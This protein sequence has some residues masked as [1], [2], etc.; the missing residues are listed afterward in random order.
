M[1]LETREGKRKKKISQILTTRKNLFQMKFTR[2]SKRFQKLTDSQED[3]RMWA[4]QTCYKPHHLESTTKSTL[5]R[6]TWKDHKILDEAS[7]AM[8]DTTC[9]KNNN[10]VIINQA[11]DPNRTYWV[12]KNSLG[13]LLEACCYVTVH[14]ITFH[15][16]NEQNYTHLELQFPRVKKRKV[17][18]NEYYIR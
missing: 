4:V 15:I 14:R 10:T 7:F 5:K 2:D 3:Q 17:Q 18:E 9:S 1:W 16:A 11:E 12:R 6:N 8:H 13:E